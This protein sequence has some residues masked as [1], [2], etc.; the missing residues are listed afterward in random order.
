MERYVER[1]RD[2][3]PYALRRRIGRDIYF[4]Q[5][6]PGVAIIAECDSPERA[7]EALSEF[8]L[9]KAGPIDREIIPR[10]AF[11]GRE[12]SFAAGDA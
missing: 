5:D 12:A 7:R 6:R 9:A 8:P 1:E 2:H 3:A 10:R 11:L 4:R